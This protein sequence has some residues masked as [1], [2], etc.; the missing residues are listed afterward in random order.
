MENSAKELSL[1]VLRHVNAR[2]SIPVNAVAFTTF[3][4]CL[5]GLINIGSTTVFND[6][7]SLTVG[8]LYFSYLI[9]S[10]LLLWRRC[11]GGIAESYD[12]IP[13]VPDA[14]DDIQLASGPWRIP[15]I[16]AIAVNILGIC[17]MIVILFFSFWPA[18]MPVTPA[19]MNYSVLVLGT[20]VIFSIL[21]YSFRAHKMYNGP[22]VERNF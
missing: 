20:V 10:I 9:C 1:T 16:P 12:L 17:Y 2:T 4:A 11:T 19:I 13:A 22:L 21:Y 15:G 3:I 7:I 8:A 6:V 18:A 14:E 5:L